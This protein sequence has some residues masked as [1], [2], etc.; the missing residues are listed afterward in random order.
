MV[1]KYSNYA[2]LKDTLI[3]AVFMLEKILMS[4]EVDPLQLL[5]TALKLC[6]T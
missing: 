6:L 1:Q 3:R 5:F 4:N 2:I